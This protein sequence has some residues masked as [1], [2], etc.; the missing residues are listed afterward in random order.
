M[1]GLARTDNFMLATATVMIGPVDDLHDL[2]PTDHSIGLVK[3]FQFNSDPTYT[4]LMQG[5]KG[6]VVFSTM[7]S[8]P[9]RASMEVYE[10]TARN[11][12]FALGL[13]G[14]TVNPMT[15]NSTVGTTVAASPAT[16]DVILATGGG[17]GFVAGD[18]ILIAKNEDDD[19]IIRKVV[20]KSTDT[21][22]VDEFLPAIPSGSV[23]YKVNAIEVGSKD[24]Q[25]FLAAKIAGKLANGKH[26]VILIPK[27]RITKGFALAFSSEN[28]G[29]LP[30]EFT[31]YDLVSTDTHYTYF[32]GAQAKIFTR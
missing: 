17:S 29:N 21:L 32:G 15:V 1:A 14:S 25:P 8:N 23:V 30:I 28:Y 10:Y 26:V 31:L 12:N 11:L 19:F 16:K 24:D 20:S 22:T 9:V 13:D 6:S 7:T 18:V 27:L 2:N 5:V 3:N 4:E